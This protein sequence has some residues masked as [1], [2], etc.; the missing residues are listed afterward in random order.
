M[1]N[2]MFILCLASISLLLS[3]CATTAN[4]AHIVHSWHGSKLNRLTHVWGYPDGHF[5]APNGHR[6]YFYRYDYHAYVPGQYFPGYSAVNYGPYGGAYIYTS[7]SYYTPG[8]SLRAFCKTFFEVNRHN[9][10]IHT[11]F[12]GNNCVATNYQVRM[13]SN[14][15]KYEYYKMKPLHK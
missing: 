1:R 3:G 2:N 14:T 8:Y 11:D 6:V 4:Y 15:G 10:I 5:K 7:P 9:T 13:L 12:R